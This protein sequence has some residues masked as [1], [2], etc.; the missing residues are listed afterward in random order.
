MRAVGLWSRSVRRVDAEADRAGSRCEIACSDRVV[1]ALR[2]V[3]ESR[4]RAAYWFAWLVLQTRAI[5]GSSG[6]TETAVAIPDVL[7]G[8]GFGQVLALQAV[9]IAGA[10][11]ATAVWRWPSILAIVLAAVAVCSKRVMATPLPWRTARCCCLRRCTCWRPAL[12]LAGSCR[13][14]SWCGRRRSLSPGLQRAGSQ[15]SRRFLSPCLPPRRCS[16]VSCS[17][18]DLRA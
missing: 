7:L 6:L 14:S 13:F 8:T 16:K 11:V 12:G 5:A 2:H 3:V 18:A 4:R 10:F 17:R 9:A 15:H 1:R